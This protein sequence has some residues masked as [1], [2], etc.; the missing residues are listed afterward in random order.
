MHTLE[1]LEA[2]RAA[3]TQ[4]QEKFDRYSGN[5]PNKFR[6]EIKSAGAAV[7]M[8][9]ASLKASGLLPRSQQEELEHRLDAAFPNA[10]SKQ[11]VEFEGK[12][13]TLRFTPAAKSN[14]GKS[15]TEWRK[16]WT[17]EE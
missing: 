13:Y 8:I 5:N 17:L 3:L 7:R 4:S 2:A 16:Y 15:V 10:Q 14:S 6:S 11:T 1:D 9:E 12:R